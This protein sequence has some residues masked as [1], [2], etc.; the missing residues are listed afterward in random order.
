[1]MGSPR[2]FLAMVEGESEEPTITDLLHYILATKVPSLVQ[3]GASILLA[4]LT[5]HRYRYRALR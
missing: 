2:L 1:M 5:Q 3:I 4:Y